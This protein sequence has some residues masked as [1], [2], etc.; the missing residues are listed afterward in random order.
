[1]KKIIIILIAVIGFGISASAQTYTFYISS[2]RFISSEGW[3]TNGY[4][5]NKIND[6]GYDYR[7]RPQQTQAKNIGAIPTG[8]YYIVGVTDSKGVN[9]IVLSQDPSNDM[10]GRDNFRIHG[11]NSSKNASQ[12]CIILDANARTKITNAFNK[13]NNRGKIDA[14]LT[15][16]VYE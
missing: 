3:T 8:T 12:G 9:T 6:D 11:D 5:G 13:W 2:G 15:L 14:Y 4:S 16:Y 10:Y 7:N 1:M